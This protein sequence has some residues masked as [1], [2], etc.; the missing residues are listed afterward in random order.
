MSGAVMKIDAAGKDIWNRSDEFYFVYQEVSGDVELRARVDGL[1]SAHSWSK[2]G[3]MIRSS[4]SAGAA[5]GFALVSAGAGTA[6]QR[7]LAK[8]GITTHSDGPAGTAP[9]WVRIVRSGSQVTASVSS[10]GANWTT[11]GSDEVALGTSAYV[12]LAVTAHNADMRTTASVSRLTVTR[13]S[14]GSGGGFP[15]TLSTEDVGSP[16]ISGSATFDNGAYTVRAAGAIGGVADQFHYV[17]QPMSGNVEVIARVASI[18]ASE[19]GPNAGVM[20]RESLAPGS[21]HAF[22]LASTKNTYAFRRRVEPGVTS[23]QTSGGQGGLPVWLRLVRTGTQFDAYRS[24]DGAN[25]IRMGSSAIAMDDTVY[26]G[27]AV[28]SQSPSAATTAIVDHLTITAAGS[29][30]NT[31]PA[32]M[33]GA[34]ANGATYTEPATV[35][36]SAS[37]SDADGVVEAVEFYANSVLVGRDT[38]APYTTAASLAAGT[39]TITAAAIDD[40]GATTVSQ[41]VTVVVSAAPTTPTPTPTPPAAPQGVA[42]TASP[43]HSTAVVSYLLEVFAA[44]ATPGVSAPV[45]R[46]NL[47]KPAPAAGGEIQVD[48]SAFFAALATGNYKA[49]VSAVGQSGSSRS[50]PVSFSR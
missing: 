1:T 49:T 29:T 18:A 19:S 11:I 34:P 10:D 9:R 3:V 22:A 46:L 6:F 24:A 32:V 35:T 47:G 27:I 13:P 31:P 16:A 36:I 48:C 20:I 7:R 25:W 41:P 44:T 8:N 28:A 2:A 33:L 21:R 5:H 15:A 37:A 43:D 14:S 30:S 4:L 23:D 17:Y 40:T 50:A 39:Y 12:G 38:A 26:V 42:F 45:A